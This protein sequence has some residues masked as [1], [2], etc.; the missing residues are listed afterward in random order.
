MHTSYGDYC[1]KWE[2]KYGSV[3]VEGVNSTVCV[4][5]I[6][7]M[8]MLVLEIILFNANNL[9]NRTDG[10]L[11]LSRMKGIYSKNLYCGGGVFFLFPFFFFFML[12]SACS[13]FCFEIHMIDLK[14]LVN[15]K[16]PKQVIVICK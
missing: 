6:C 11:G 15:D 14:S 16:H 9:T 2:L 13:V 1:Q 4:V 3:M 12:R 8:P 5:L 7:D 10:D